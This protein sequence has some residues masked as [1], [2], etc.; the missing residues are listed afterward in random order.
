MGS[1]LPGAIVRLARWRSESESLTE[2]CTDSWPSSFRAVFAL[3]LQWQYLSAQLT[4]QTLQ[5]VE[6]LFRGQHLISWYSG[7]CV[8][9]APLCATEAGP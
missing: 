8:A 1:H 7:A 4:K 5:K 9:G 3:R 2:F 6:A